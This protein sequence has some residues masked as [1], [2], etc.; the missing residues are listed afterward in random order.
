MP[1]RTSK[2]TSKNSNR[3]AVSAAWHDC[4]KMKNKLLVEEQERQALL[5][6]LQ[7]TM[8]KLKN[9]DSGHRTSSGA[10]IVTRQYNFGRPTQVTSF[11]SPLP[12]SPSSSSSG[13]LTPES[14]LSSYEIHPGLHGGG[15]KKRKTMRKKG[16]SKGR[17]SKG[18]KSKGRKTKGRKSKRRC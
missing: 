17:K 6:N 12:L 2:K 18:R 7:D 16:K 4:I 11:P 9:L 5:K 13:A 14:N 15:K 3:Q 8:D 10:N 1:R